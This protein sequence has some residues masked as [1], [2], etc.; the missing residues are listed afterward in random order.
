MNIKSIT[1]FILLVLAVSSITLYNDV[2]YNMTQ[3]KLIL[4]HT[5]LAFCPQS[6]LENWSCLYCKQLPGVQN[7]KYLTNKIT[8]VAGFAGYDPK[9]NA[10][11][12]SFR[13][14]N[15]SPNWF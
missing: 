8:K 12:V 9:Q 11:I 5:A 14:S 1:I 13:G 10:V 7:V 2:P 3:S 15:N 6:C 4:F